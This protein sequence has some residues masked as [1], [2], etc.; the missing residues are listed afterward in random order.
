MKDDQRKLHTS[1]LL[2]VAA[3]LVAGLACGVK[4][5]ILT[6]DSDKKRTVIWMLLLFLYMAAL[7]LTQAMRMWVV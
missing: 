7:F 2:L 4:K 1:T 6:G 5:M 3:A